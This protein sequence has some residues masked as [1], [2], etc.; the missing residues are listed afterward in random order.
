MAMSCTKPKEQL[1]HESFV[2]ITMK[3]NAGS[4]ASAVLLQVFSPPH[5]L[6]PTCVRLHPTRH[7]Q[8]QPH[9]S[10]D[11]SAL[12]AL[13]RRSGVQASSMDLV[14]EHDMFLQL[15]QVTERA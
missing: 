8:Q 6:H 10:D 11:N 4:N 9:T 1:M 14:R 12:E 7:P 3:T 15:L 13:A 5:A 2:S